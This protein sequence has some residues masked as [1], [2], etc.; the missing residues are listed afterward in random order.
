MVQA[1]LRGQEKVIQPEGGQP[2]AGHLQ[3]L[4]QALVDQ[5]KSPLD[6]NVG[7]ADGSL[8]EGRGKALLRE[9]QFCL[10]LEALPATLGVGKLT[11]DSRQ[12]ALQM[13]FEHI[14]MGPG[15]HRV[16]GRNFVNRAGNDDERNIQPGRLHEG[17]RIARTEAGQGI[18]GD[19]QVPRR[20][21]RERFA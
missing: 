17:Q 9:Q 8:I 15:S 14:V 19:H 3:Q 7:H 10:R 18:V 12:Q 20:W 13:A 2:F 11:L 16:H 21:R 4:S 5:Q 6:G 1:P